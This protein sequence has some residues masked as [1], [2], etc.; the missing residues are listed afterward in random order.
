MRFA[1]VTCRDTPTNISLAERSP[2]DARWEPM[3]PKQALE[4]LGPGDAVLGRLDVLPTLD[5]M[6]D[7]LWALGA[8]AARGVVVL[9]DP[10]A[11]LA[12]H[13]KLLTARILRRH[14]LPHPATTHVRDGRSIPRSDRPLVLKPRF[15]SWGLEVRLCEDHESLVEAIEAV[16]DTHWY[17]RHG[18]LVQELVQPQGYDLRIVV[19]AGRV[20]G[21]VYRVAAPGE[22]RT[23]V[24][25]GGVRR[26]VTEPPRAAAALA[27][28]AARA[29][30]V[31]LVGVDLLPDRDGSW[32]VAELN[33]AVEFTEEYAPWGDIFAETATV[34]GAAAR[35]R[36]ERRAALA[37]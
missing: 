5:G 26:T 2:L 35:D 8:L 29:S 14:D 1:V 34:L 22:W 15:G 19:A 33:G 12:A 10:P 25:L 36:L 30:G 16:R 37:A 23:N 27:L 4:R 9:N 13:D 11:L 6:D 20:V 24:A 17:R 28:E 32:V 31:D 7:G 3:T 21:A 18:V